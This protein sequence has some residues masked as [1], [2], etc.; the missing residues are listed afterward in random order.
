MKREGCLLTYIFLTAA[1]TRTKFL[2]SV[3]LFV[4]YLKKK[5]VSFFFALDLVRVLQHNTAGADTWECAQEKSIGFYKYYAT[6]FI[7][8]NMIHDMCTWATQIKPFLKTHI[9][10]VI[11]IEP[12]LCCAS[13]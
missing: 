3:H 6:K 1:Y 7:Y 5:V 10:K 12:C 8:L 9:N 4:V 11:V 2:K 13:V